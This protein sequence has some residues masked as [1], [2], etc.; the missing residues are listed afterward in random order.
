M[1]AV[2]DKPTSSP[3]EAWRLIKIDNLKRLR[4]VIMIKYGTISTAAVAMGVKY[5]ALSHTI[6]GRYS[7][8]PQIRA[9]QDDLSLTNEQVLQIWPLLGQWPKEER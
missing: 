3:A 8:T 7:Y 1:Q 9:L 2:I 4:A 6:N 5:T